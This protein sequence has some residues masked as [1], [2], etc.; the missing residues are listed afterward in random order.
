MPTLVDGI[1]DQEVTPR[2]KLRGFRKKGGVYVHRVEQITHILDVQYSR[3]ND[4]SEASF[5]LNCGVHVPNVTSKFRGRPEPKWPK[6][7]DSCLNVR[8][9]MLRA[10]HVDV[11]W[12]LNIGSTRADELAV[13]ADI[14]SVIEEWIFPF[15]DRFAEE[16]AVAKFLSNRPSSADE[17]I[18]PRSESLRSSY[19]AIIWRLLGHAAKSNMSLNDAIMRSKGT[20]LEE[21]VVAFSRRFKSETK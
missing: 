11:W 2:L 1:V 16:E 13:R 21:T 14:R 8:P 20:P 4:E 15:F 5:T 9:A 19:A 6:P 7:T 10:P 3:W 12:K 17:F 18:E